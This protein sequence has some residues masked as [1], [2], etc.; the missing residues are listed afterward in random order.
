MTHLSNN[1]IKQKLEEMRFER[2]AK[3]TAQVKTQCIANERCP[4]CTLKLPCKH[5]ESSEQVFDKGRLFKRQEWMA[6]TSEARDEI[7]KLKL[8]SQIDKKPTSPCSKSTASVSPAKEKKP[9]IRIRV[10]TAN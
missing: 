7:V 6:I 8:K 1:G 4:K 2:L 3:N 5:F 10:Q 9:R